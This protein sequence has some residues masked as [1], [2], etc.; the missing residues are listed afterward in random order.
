MRLRFN[1]RSPGR[2]GRLVHDYHHPGSARA[3]NREINLIIIAAQLT[4]PVI[5]STILSSCMTHP[6]GARRKYR[7][8]QL[9]RP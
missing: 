3:L 6:R 2:R 4:S 9:G 8:L 5:R 1:F 7:N